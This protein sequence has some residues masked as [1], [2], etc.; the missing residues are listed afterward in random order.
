MY[1]SIVVVLVSKQRSMI[2]TFVFTTEIR[3]LEGDCE[4]P[5]P[6]P[7]KPARPVLALEPIQFTAASEGSTP[8]RVGA[9]SGIADRMVEKQ[10]AVGTSG[11]GGHGTRS[12]PT[13]KVRS[14]SPG[15]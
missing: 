12:S 3:N 15:L 4:L 10:F 5:S 9:V 1:P 13:V 11:L 7:G 14:K 6:P 8:T 2:E